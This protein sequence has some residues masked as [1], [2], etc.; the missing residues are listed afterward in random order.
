MPHTN[1]V[2]LI[3][4]K[5]SE[6][7]KLLIKRKTGEDIPF[8][9]EKDDKGRYNFEIN[10]QHRSLLKLPRKPILSYDPWAIYRIIANQ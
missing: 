7:I 6:A 5:V 4:Q 2:N 10:H 8:S 9:L 3:F 1:R